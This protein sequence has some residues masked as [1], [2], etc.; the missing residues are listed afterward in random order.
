[1]QFY[2]YSIPIKKG[3]AY[4]FFD[5]QEKVCFFDIETTGLSPEVSSL[6]LIGAMYARENTLFIKQW[7]ADHIGEEKQLLEAFFDF[8]KTYRVLV[9]FNGKHFDIPYVQAK[10]TALGIHADFDD[11]KQ[12]DILASFRPYKKVFHMQSIRQKAL[13][14]FLGIFRD[15]TYDGGELIQVYSNYMQSTLISGKENEDLRGL[16]LLHNKEDVENMFYVA[17][18]LS[19]TYIFGKGFTDSSYVLIG[20]EKKASNIPGEFFLCFTLQLKH[21]VPQPFCFENHGIN[22]SLKSNEAQ[23]SI[24]ILT[25]E[26][27]H[28]FKDYKNYY[29]LPEEDTAV[30][31]SVAS[32]VDAAYRKKATASN[33]YIRKTGEFL[34]LKG[35]CNSPVF[36]T[37]Y[38]DKARYI[39]YTED[40]FAEESFLAEYVANILANLL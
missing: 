29:Y 32:Y 16:L 26:F 5:A 11:L 17:S 10:C 8:L 6:Y 18:M 37:S 34:P 19:Y 15:D 22:L 2:E 1:M 39:A 40:T 28:F 25:G 30:H 4:P 24:P 12:I 3:F 23:L 21:P 31:K 36:Q 27:K 14:H 9:H 38:K 33:C 13:E 7:F 20:Y 35:T